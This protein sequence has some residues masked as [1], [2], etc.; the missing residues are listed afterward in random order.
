MKIVVSL[1]KAFSD[2]NSNVVQNTGLTIIKLNIVEEGQKL[3]T[4][5][6]SFLYNDFK[7]LTPKC[8]G[9]CHCVVKGKINASFVFVICIILLTWSHS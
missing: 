1:L 6:F 7:G 9:K 2:N 4:R 5:I 8:C 3:I